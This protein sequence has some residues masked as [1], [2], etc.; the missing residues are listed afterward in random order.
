MTASA[1]HWA[2]CAVLPFVLIPIAFVVTRIV[3]FGFP[4]LFTSVIPIAFPV[5]LVLYYLAWK[6]VV[7]FLNR[8]QAIA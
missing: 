2:T 3:E 4:A 1:A 7:G 6:Y 5:A 8:V